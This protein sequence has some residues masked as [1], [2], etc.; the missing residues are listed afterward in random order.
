MSI[1]WLA[2]Q[3][4]LFNSDPV[5]SG[6][7]LVCMNIARPAWLC[8]CLD[9]L[10]RIKQPISD[11]IL[12]YEQWIFS[13]CCMCSHL[14]LWLLVCMCVSCVSNMSPSVTCATS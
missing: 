10:G 7:H 5:I 3:A 1:R 2:R 9:I 4:S 8:L 11:V 12:G 6:C 14:C 13:W